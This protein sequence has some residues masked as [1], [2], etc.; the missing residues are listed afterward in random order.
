MA[1]FTVH[2]EPVEIVGPPMMDLLNPAT[3]D[4]PIVKVRSLLDPSWV[5]QASLSR[6][7]AD[8]GLKEIHDACNAIG[9]GQ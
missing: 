7:R 4:D 6:L 3:A 8:G 5:R 1:I 9:A 2:G